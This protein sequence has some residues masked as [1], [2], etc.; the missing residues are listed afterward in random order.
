MRSVTAIFFSLS[1]RFFV[2]FNKG[3]DFIVAEN[4][5]PVFRMVEDFLYKVI[6][7]CNSPFLQPV[8]NICPAA[9]RAYLDGLLQADKG[10][11]YTGVD[12]IGKPP[13]L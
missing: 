9:D 1:F 8:F 11:R 5:V 4:P 3:V 7:Y 6:G 2:L 10:G 13:V 12:I